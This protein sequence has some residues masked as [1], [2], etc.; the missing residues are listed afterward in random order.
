VAATCFEDL[1][2]RLSEF[3][4]RHFQ[5][6]QDAPEEEAYGDEDF[7][8]KSEDSDEYDEED[9]DDY[10]DEEAPE[11]EYDDE[12]PEGEYDKGPEDEP[13]RPRSGSGVGTRR[14]R[15]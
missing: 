9:P 8:E 5:P 11:A 2:H 14:S 3:E 4:E 10:D 1:Q 15:S 6:P 7:E 12:K 13:S